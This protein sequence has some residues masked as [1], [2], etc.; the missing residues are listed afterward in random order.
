MRSWVLALALVACGK[1]E[2]K[3]VGT[4][5]K[6][7]VFADIFIAE[8]A[9][10]TKAYDPETDSWLLTGPG[11]KTTVRIERADERYVASPDAYMEHLAPRWKGK[12]VT[13]ED[14]DPIRSSGFAMTLGV[15]A[16]ENDA[17]PI[18]TAVAVGK[19]G[20]VWYRCMSDGAYDDNVRVFVTWLCKSVHR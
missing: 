16:G 13:I 4:V 19:L 3:Q 15:Y 8:P 11:A 18:R 9:D 12:L 20:T 17:N 7:S 5:V 6:P 14:R 2:P 10:W 1:D